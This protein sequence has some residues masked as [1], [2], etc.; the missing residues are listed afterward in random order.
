[1]SKN[2]ALTQARRLVQ[3]GVD[4]ARKA[5]IDPA[6]VVEPHCAEAANEDVAKSESGHMT[7]C[8]VPVIIDNH[9][10]EL[11]EMSEPDDDPDQKPSFVVTQSTANLVQQDFERYKPSLERM[12]EDWREAKKPVA[13]EETSSDG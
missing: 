2:E 5:G 9:T 7:W 12:V 10:T 13:S 8:C 3:E 11:F 1:M 6:L 4:V